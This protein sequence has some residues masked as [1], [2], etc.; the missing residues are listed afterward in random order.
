MKPG[1][2]VRGRWVEGYI[3]M[4]EKIHGIYSAQFLSTEI[5]MVLDFGYSN[6]DVPYVH[7]LTS[8]GK[9]GW[10]KYE[11]VRVIQIE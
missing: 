9:R 2:M 4:Y 5:G 8:S 1:D 10:V 3:P 11:Q 6:T 7:I